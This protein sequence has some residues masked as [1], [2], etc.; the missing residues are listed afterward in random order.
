M[1]PT[2]AQ[3]WQKI[4]SAYLNDTLDPYR[5]CACFIGNMLNGKFSWSLGRT[6]DGDYRV[7]PS[8]NKRHII[9][10]E[11]CIAKEA[12][13]LYTIEDICRLEDNF[14]QFAI[15]APCSPNYENALYEA[16]VSTLELLRQIHISK[17]E[18]VD[19]LPLVKREVKTF[20]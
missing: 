18:D 13:G 1:Q 14:L 8:F 17:G 6:I 4:T 12:G 16:M 7:V 10:A 11:E 20:A 3:Q 5:N 2:Y 9:I 15:A 19:A